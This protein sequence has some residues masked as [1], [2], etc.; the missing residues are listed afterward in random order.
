MQDFGQTA[1]SLTAKWRLS[2]SVRTAA[3]SQCCCY[4]L[5]LEGVDSVS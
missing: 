1:G 2:C 4:L 3:G 5:N